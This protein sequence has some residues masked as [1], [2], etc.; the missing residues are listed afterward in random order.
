MNILFLFFP[1]DRTTIYRT[2]KLDIDSKNCFILNKFLHAVFY[3]YSGQNVQN[4]V[5]QKDKLS[6]LARVIRLFT[7]RHMFI[8]D[9]DHRLPITN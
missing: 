4:V 5:V 7:V 1:H 8:Y 2:G 9:S 6:H 3:L